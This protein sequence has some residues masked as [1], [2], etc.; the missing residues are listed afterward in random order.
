MAGERKPRILP[1]PKGQAQAQAQ[2][3]APQPN[4]KQ[5]DA[6][7]AEPKKEA[8]KDPEDQIEADLRK[9]IWEQVAEEVDTTCAAWKRRNKRIRRT[10]RNGSASNPVAMKESHPPGRPPREGSDR[11][12]AHRFDGM[13]RQRRTARRR[14]PQGVRRAADRRSGRRSCR[15]RRT[16][17]NRWPPSTRR[18]AMRRTKVSRWCRCRVPVRLQASRMPTASRPTHRR[19]AAGGRIAGME[20]EGRVPNSPD[21]HEPAVRETAAALCRRFVYRAPPRRKPS[22]RRCATTANG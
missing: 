1:I 17:A 15:S 3:P 14:P 20:S 16:V 18:G 4:G 6:K 19:C 11:L 12:L 7:T 8:P 5:S 10:V 13:V 2:G 22:R 21:R 9:N